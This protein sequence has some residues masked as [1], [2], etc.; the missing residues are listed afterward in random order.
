MQKI[1]KFVSEQQSS[2]ISNLR[3]LHVDLHQHV[4]VIIIIIVPWIQSH[5]SQCLNIWEI[6][7]LATIFVS[8]EI[9]IALQFFSQFNLTGQRLC[10]LTPTL[11]PG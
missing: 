6:P 5:V 11:T 9:I 2:I 3:L 10:S 8:P 7:L 1:R 4:T